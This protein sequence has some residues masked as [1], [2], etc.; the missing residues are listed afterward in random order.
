ML[1]YIDG[2]LWAQEGVL[3]RLGLNLAQLGAFVSRQE[4]PVRWW[5]WGTLLEDAGE[6]GPRS[7][8]S[9]CVLQ[10]MRPTFPPPMPPVKPGAGGAN[11]G[12]TQVSLSLPGRWAAGRETLPLAGWLGRCP[13]GD[14]VTVHQPCF[15]SHLTLWRD[16]SVSR[17]CGP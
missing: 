16:F 7:M 6:D 10:G 13:E 5:T 12:P 8:M 11:P 2:G 14:T 3:P 1:R 15:N 4:K 17:S 9:D